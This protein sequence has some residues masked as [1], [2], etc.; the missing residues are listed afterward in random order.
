MDVSHAP[1]VAMFCFHEDMLCRLSMACWLHVWES[2]F[3]FNDC[4]VDMKK[5]ILFGIYQY[6]KKGE[7]TFFAFAASVLN[8]IACSS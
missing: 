5:F 2:R 4:F 1:I 3:S 6:C 8:F 7:A